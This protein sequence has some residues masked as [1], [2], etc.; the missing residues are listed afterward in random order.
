MLFDSHDNVRFTGD[1]PRCHSWGQ[2]RTTVPGRLWGTPKPGPRAHLTRL[3]VIS[4][5]APL[6]LSV[7]LCVQT[8]CPHPPFSHGAQGHRGRAAPSGGPRPPE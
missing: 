7:S 6:S 5:P 1:L 8:R 3:C 2:T 4:A